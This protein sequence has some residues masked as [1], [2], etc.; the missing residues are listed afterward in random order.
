MQEKVVSLNALKDL[1][2][3]AKEKINEAIQFAK[4]KDTRRFEFEKW[5]EPKRCLFNDSEEINSLM[6]K[7]IHYANARY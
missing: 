2:V 3:K 6:R 4:Y 7:Y 5:F 1:K